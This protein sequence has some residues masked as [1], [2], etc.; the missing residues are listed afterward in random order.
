MHYVQL[1]RSAKLLHILI[2]VIN[3]GMIGMTSNLF[4]VSAHREICCLQQ[5]IHKFAGREFP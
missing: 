2:I 5:K 1:F 4:F 3:V